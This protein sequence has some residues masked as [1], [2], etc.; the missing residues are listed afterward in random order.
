MCA[1]TGLCPGFTT[2]E[3]DPRKC[4][5][6]YSFFTRSET[7]SDTPSIFGITRCFTFFERNDIA[8]LFFWRLIELCFW[9]SEVK[10]IVTRHGILE[11]LNLFLG[12]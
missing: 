5:K 7:F 10:P 9:V 8:L 3:K 12:E 1:E 11:T 4:Y 6:S 2:Q